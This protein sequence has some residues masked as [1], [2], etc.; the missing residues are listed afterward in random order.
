MEKPCD[1]HFKAIQ[2]ILQYLKGTIG[3]GIIFKCYNTLSLLGYFD[4]YYAT[5]IDTRRSITCLCISIGS[6]LVAWKSKKQFILSR[7]SVEAE[8]RAMA[9]AAAEITWFRYLLQDFKLEVPTLVT[10]FCDNQVAMQIA[11]NPVFYERT[12]YIEVDCHYMSIFVKKVQYGSIKIEN[13]PSSDQLV[14]IFT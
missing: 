11:A 2:R 4:A 3:Q 8:Y 1:V 14:D 7:S 5:G 12:K 6:S 9:S 13:V 10:L